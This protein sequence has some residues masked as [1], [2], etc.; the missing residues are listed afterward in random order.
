[1]A[2]AAGP[3]PWSV[4]YASEDFIA[5]NPAAISGFRAAIIE[6]VAWLYRHSSEE[7][8]KVLQPFFRTAR[9]EHVTRGLD[10]L[11]T[12][13]TWPLDAEH[14]GHALERYKDF[15]IDYGLLDAPKLPAA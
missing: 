6:A 1:M 9:P 4:Y 14:E 15:M 5:G 2:E 13:R 11:K 12:S 10:L 3:V 7:A 8:A